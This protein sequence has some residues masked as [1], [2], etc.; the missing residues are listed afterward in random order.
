M[1]IAAIVSG[2]PGPGRLTGRAATRPLHERRGNTQRGM[3][4]VTQMPK[5]GAHW[6]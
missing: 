4:T 1:T 5:R 3:S 6:R 2:V